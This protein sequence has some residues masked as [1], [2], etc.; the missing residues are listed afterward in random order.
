MV[1]IDLDGNNGDLPSNLDPFYVLCD[2]ESQ[3][4]VGITVV[5]H[6]G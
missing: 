5:Q 6:S 4:H 3:H 1:Y 2:V